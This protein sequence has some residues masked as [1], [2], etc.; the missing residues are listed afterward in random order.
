[1]A[2]TAVKIELKDTRRQVSRG[3][4]TKAKNLP[5]LHDK[6]VVDLF[7]QKVA[8]IP[9]PLNL[10][11]DE[12]SQEGLVIK[13]RLKARKLARSILRKWH[14]RLDLQEV[15]SIVDLSLC[16]AVIRYNPAKGA[17]FMT[18]LFY[19]L[20]GNLIR[21]VS[22]AASLNTIPIADYEGKGTASA[23]TE[24]RPVN[25]RTANAIEIAEALSSQDFML[26]DE[27]LL[28]KE[29]LNMSSDAC[30]RLDPLEKEI[31][32][33]IYMQEQQLMDIAHTLGYSRCHISRVKKK[34]LE[35]LHADL[36][37]S[38]GVEAQKRIEFEDEDDCL[39]LRR[40]E[41]RKIHRRRP[42]SKSSAR[43]REERLTMVAAC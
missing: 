11:E 7:P 27:M 38:L 42:R 36:T 17:S 3:L 16:E 13:Y 30:S 6:K 34:A 26:P 25:Y 43:A 39:Q 21:A 29:L 15:D 9:E 32:E 1:M 35:A 33:R 40:F 23:T 4:K 22:V 8:P 37:T 18:F 12:S 10:V 19:H 5:R 41:R 2:A 28:K 20:R 24:E 31:I 14:A